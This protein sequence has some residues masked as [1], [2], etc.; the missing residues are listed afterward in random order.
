MN[1]TVTNLNSLSNP[2][3]G[4]LLYMVDVSE[5]LGSPSR[6]KKITKQELANS[7]AS[8]YGSANWLD[9]VLTTSALSGIPSPSLG[10]MVF[11]ADD[12]D[13]KGAQYH[14]N[15]TSWVKIADV[16]WAPLTEAQVKELNT[17][18][19]SVAKASHGFSVGDPLRFDE[20]SSYVKATASSE[21]NAR[22]AG[23]VSSVPDSDNFVIQVSGLYTLSGAFSAYTKNTVLY[24][25]DTGTLDSS[26]GS[27]T[28]PIGLVLD[29]NTLL[30]RFASGAGGG[31]LAVVEVVD[32]TARLALTGIKTGQ[33]VFETTNNELYSLQDDSSISSASSWL[34]LSDISP[35]QFTPI[36]LQPDQDAV[37]QSSTVSNT[38]RLVENLGIFYLQKPDGTRYRLDAKATAFSGIIPGATPDQSIHPHVSSPNNHLL[39]IITI[40]GVVRAFVIPSDGSTKKE[41]SLG[42]STEIDSAEQFDLEYTDVDNIFGLGASEKYSLV[43]GNS[44][45]VGVNGIP[46]VQNLQPAD[47]GANPRPLI[48]SGGEDS[49]ANKALNK[50]LNRQDYILRPYLGTIANFRERA[51]K[52]EIATTDEGLY[53][54]ATKDAAKFFGAITATADSGGFCKFTVTSTTNLEVGDTV[55]VTGHATSGLQRVTS[56]DSAT[57]FTTNEA[58]QAGTSGGV[59]NLAN[60]ASAGVNKQLTYNEIYEQN[61]PG[62]YIAS[63]NSAVVLL[64]PEG[65]FYQTNAVGRT[66]VIP[67]ATPDQQV[68]P[69][70]TSPDQHLLELITINGVVR[71]FVIPSD[72]ST[73]KEI[74]L[75]ISAALDS[76]E[77]FDFEYTDV[78]NAIGLGATESFSL[79]TGNSDVKGVNGLSIVQNLQPA[80]AGSNPYPLVI[81]GGYGASTDKP[82]G[83]LLDKSYFVVVPFKGAIDTF[84]LT[85]QAGEECLNSTASAITGV[86]A[87]ANKRYTCIKTASREIDGTSLSVPITSSAANSGDIQF[88]CT[89]TD[90]TVLVNPGDIIHTTGCDGDATHNGQHKVTAVTATT[91]TVDTTFV[92]ADST[93][94]LRLSALVE[95]VTSTGI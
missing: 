72:G 85:A 68:I 50:K 45:S 14:Y 18:T 34:R 53:V 5:P 3:N 71:A 17:T 27:E 76:A 60:I 36:D 75:G 73:K 65:V 2:E 9:P 55:R 35:G 84:L 41:V 92:G 51:E 81:S 70:V 6:S 7:L 40:N 11:V 16:D 86:T 44:D 25:S 54:T 19:L 90:L 21:T 88:T 47:A 62:V 37:F 43:S 83:K 79:I 77:Q 10:D 94:D 87:P 91:I 46:L 49:Y 24:L 13:G 32:T 95:L 22:V 30:L 28:A 39:E 48:I 29:A 82:L 74:S 61:A 58:Y 15:G 1:S 56:V 78:D 93:G 8:F 26:E 69:H 38:L 23:I 57:E 64:S 59:H 42:I 63:D 12:G 66:S 80:D 31:N 52:G 20:A 4:D 89:A 67:G 33:L